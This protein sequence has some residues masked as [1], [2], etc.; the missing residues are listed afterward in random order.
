MAEGRT[1]SVGRRRRRIKRCKER[2]MIDRLQLCAFMRSDRCQR[3]LVG[4]I[5]REDGIVDARQRRRLL[6]R[7]LDARLGP[8]IHPGLV[9]L[10][11]RARGVVETKHGRLL[12]C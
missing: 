12:F 11:D 9:T 10:I 2:L 1:Q 6:D 5:H 3:G 8:E 7:S 4:G